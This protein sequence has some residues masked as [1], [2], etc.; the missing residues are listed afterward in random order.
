MEE[1]SVHLRKR[2]YE[3]GRHGASFELCLQL[4]LTLTHSLVGQVSIDVIPDNVLLEIFSFYVERIQIM[5]RWHTLT[6]VCRSW[7]NIVFASPHRLNLQL[8][9]TNKRPVKDMLDIW[10]T[11]LPIIIQYRSDSLFPEK[12][13]D[14]IFAALEHRDRV[15]EI[16]FRLWDVSSSITERFVAMTR[17]PFPALT[18]L[19]LGSNTEWAPA[20]PDSF[21]C[22]S[23]PRLQTLWL[24]NIPFPTLPKLLMSVSDLVHLDLLSIPHSTYTSHPR[25]WS[26]ACPGC[27]RSN[28]L[29][30]NSFRLDLAPMG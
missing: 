12:G 11:T 18:S 8:L 4:P 29:T 6:H 27:P 9:C 23:A 22:G 25:R 13:A 26:R 17:E 7:R 21:L 15:C 30:S 1:Y 19:C 10:P 16:D 24:V 28:R 20:I 3:G 2:S 5:G 14:N